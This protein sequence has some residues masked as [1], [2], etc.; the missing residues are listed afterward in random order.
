[1]KTLRPYQESAVN[2]LDKDNK[3]T[4]PFVVRNKQKRILSICLK[5]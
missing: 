4:Y 3:E 2:A 1:M 5:K